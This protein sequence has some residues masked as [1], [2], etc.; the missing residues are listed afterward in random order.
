MNMRRWESAV[1]QQIRVGMERG[2]FDE[3]PGKGKPIDGL[4]ADHDDD[5][6]LKA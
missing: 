3:L 1:E 4:G 2:E 5:W 6:W